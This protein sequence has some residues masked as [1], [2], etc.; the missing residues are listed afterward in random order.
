MISLRNAFTVAC[1]SSNVVSRRPS[2]FGPA[3][4][5]LDPGPDPVADTDS[6]ALNR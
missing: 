2:G 6:P 5:D 4:P 1:V 3:P